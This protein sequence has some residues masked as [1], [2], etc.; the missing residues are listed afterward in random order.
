MPDNDRNRFFILTQEQVKAG[1]KE[2]A[3]TSEATIKAGIDKFPGV[4]WKFAEK[5]EDVWKEALP[6]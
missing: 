3:D 5:F 4:K 2:A 6:P 1:I